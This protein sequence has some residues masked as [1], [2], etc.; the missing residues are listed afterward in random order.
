[1]V[2]GLAW[3]HFWPLLHGILPP[4]SVGLH[5]HWV[6]ALVTPPPAA[7]WH[8][9]PT[10]AATLLQGGTLPAPAPHLSL[11]RPWRPWRH[12]CE[13]LQLPLSPGPRQFSALSQPTFTLSTVLE[14]RVLFPT[15]LALASS[16]RAKPPS[17]VLCPWRASSLRFQ[18]F[19]LS[20]DLSSLVC[21]RKGI[22]L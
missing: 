19:C 15:C 10:V 9:L 6:T 2:N 14:C 4:L 5:L 18:A 20:Y 3:G 13:C 11:E 16:S 21:S 1:M 17:C 7:V 12:A 8:A 22:I